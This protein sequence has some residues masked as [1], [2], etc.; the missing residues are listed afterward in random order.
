LNAA[1]SLEQRVDEGRGRRSAQ[2]QQYPK[3]QQ[4]QDNG[5]QPPFLVVFE[6]V[7]V[8]PEGRIFLCVLALLV[9]FLPVGCSTDAPS[10][11]SMT[12]LIRMI[13]SQD[14]WFREEINKF[15]EE[16]NV[17]LN[18]ISYDKI[19]DVE[20]TL[21]L[22]KGAGVKRIGLVKTH[23]SMVV[24]LA[25]SGLVLPLSDI[26]PEQQ[27]EQ[28]LSEYLGRA[29]EIGKYT[30]PGETEGNYYYLPRKLETN[31]LLFLKSKVR[32]AVA[33]WRRLSREINEVFRAQ[34]G[35]G[36]PVDYELEDETG[37]WNWYDLAV[38]SYFWP[39]TSYDGVLR[40][41]DLPH[42]WYHSWGQ[43]N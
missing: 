31:T 21:R 19:S 17:A 8:H 2:Y 42:E 30:A 38:V 14:L 12:L 39:K 20:S 41:S 25:A 6:K 34:N 4:H 22:E 32:E 40:S 43:V 13:D 5:S 7:P 26:V 35:V 27:L 16:H 18:I 29:L 9:L 11:K 3:E 10:I 1:D 24:P 15:A 36:L 37:Q 33:N 23:K 28:D